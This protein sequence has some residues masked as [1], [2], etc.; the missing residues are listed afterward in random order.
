MTHACNV[1]RT[2]GPKKRRGT[3]HAKLRVPLQSGHL[4]T[5]HAYN[6]HLGLSGIERK[7]Q[8]RRAGHMP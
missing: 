1:D 5:L 6:L 2:I 7:I 8:I 3:L 4:R